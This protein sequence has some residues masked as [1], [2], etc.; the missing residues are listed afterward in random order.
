MFWPNMHSSMCKLSLS[1]PWI[2]SGLDV[3]ETEKK[4]DSRRTV[5]HRARLHSCGR[6]RSRYRVSKG[7]DP[8]QRQTW[9]RGQ[10]SLPRNYHR[11]LSAPPS[12]KSTVQDGFSSE[13]LQKQRARSCPFAYAWCTLQFRGAHHGELVHAGTGPHRRVQLPVRTGDLAWEL[14]HGTLPLLWAN[15]QYLRLGPRPLEAGVGCGRRV[16]RPEPQPAVPFGPRLLRE[17]I[18]AHCPSDLRRSTSG[19]S[20]TKSEWLTHRKASVSS[21]CSRPLSTTD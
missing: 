14:R 10:F 17:L 2:N 4:L 7:C 5:P 20:L 3:V 18:L 19:S 21:S 11:A 13:Q 15:R 1:T 12:R 9:R 8:E 16:T 6:Q